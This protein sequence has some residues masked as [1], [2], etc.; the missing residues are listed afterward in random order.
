[1]KTEIELPKPEEITESNL[2]I[3]VRKLSSFIENNVNSYCVERDEKLINYIDSEINDCNT[4]ILLVGD[5][6]NR[7]RVLREKIKAL[8]N[9]KVKHLSNTKR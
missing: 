9:C 5:D 1:M 2:L 8:S 4:G 6:T 3:S 7:L